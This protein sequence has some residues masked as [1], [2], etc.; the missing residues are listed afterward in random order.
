VV[1]MLQRKVKYTV[2]VEYTFS[3]SLPVLEINKQK[4]A[5]IPGLLQ[6]GSISELGNFTQ[7]FVGAAC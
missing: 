6:C 1:Q 3:A 7:D 4:C 5:F 2:Y